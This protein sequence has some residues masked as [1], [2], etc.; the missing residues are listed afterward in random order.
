MPHEHKNDFIGAKEFDTMSAAWFVSYCHYTLSVGCFGSTYWKK[1]TS[2][3][4][5]ASRKN[6][7]NKAKYWIIDKGT[8]VKTCQ[9]D[10]DCKS[11]LSGHKN[12]ERILR[13]WMRKILAMEESNM[14]TRNGKLK[15]KIGL[16]YQT[17]IILA[18]SC[19]PFL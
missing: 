7:F 1:I 15:N 14:Y 13:Y 9:N 6:A 16:D 17:M 8:V 10:E 2:P 5:Q 3:R 12:S 19:C 11:Y 4:S 18:S